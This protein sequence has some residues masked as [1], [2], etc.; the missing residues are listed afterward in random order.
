MAC[1]I[2]YN[3]LP[4]DLL[5]SQRPDTTGRWL[6]MVFDFV[7]RRWIERVYGHRDHYGLSLSFESPMNAS[8]SLVINLTLLPIFL[9]N[10][11][12]FFARRFTS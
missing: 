2:S 7:H 1:H 9:A 10:E 5:K 6:D 8:S 12:V 3:E 11:C 4:L